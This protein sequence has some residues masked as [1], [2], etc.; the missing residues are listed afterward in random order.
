MLKL[1]Q[2]T[3]FYEYLNTYASHHPETCIDHDVS[4]Y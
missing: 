4:D 1:Y 2:L 3:Q